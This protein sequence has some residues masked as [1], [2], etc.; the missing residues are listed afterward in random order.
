M[1]LE[2]VICL[3]L[4]PPHTS[5]PNTLLAHNKPISR[6]NLITTSAMLNQKTH[7]RAD[8]QNKKEFVL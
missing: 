5:V 2:H 3:W 8:Q 1:G 6:F 4:M 7:N